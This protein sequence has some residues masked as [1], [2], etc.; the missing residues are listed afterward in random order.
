MIA[1]LLIIFASSG[2]GAGPTSGQIA[3][4]AGTEQE[5]RCVHV[6][7]VASGALA[8][9]GQGRRDGAPTW[10][11]DG[12][13]LA[14]VTD[15]P[16]KGTGVRLVHSDGSG[17]QILGHSAENV[18]GPARWSPDGSKLAYTSGEGLVQRVMV[19]DITSGQETAW[20]G[21]KVPLL[22][23][24][25]VN[26]SQ[27]VAVGV[28]GLPGEQ[29]TDLYW[30]TPKGANPAAELLASTGSYAE[31]APAADREGSAIAYESND[32]GDREIFVHIMKRGTVDVSNHRTPDWNPVVSPDGAWVAFESF[33]TG[34]RGIFRVNPVRVLVSEVAASAEWDD[35]APTWSPDGAWVAF[36]SNRTGAPRLHV[37]DLTGE[38]VKA[39][40]DHPLQDLA[41][42]WRPESK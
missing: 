21:D 4:L 29:T 41:P 37:T 2:W 8:K 32:G 34:R 18:M 31:W 17:E 14:Y 1:S 28:V 16:E 5:D 23:P 9:V 3:F 12:A 11:P 7:D 36:I 13:W 35:W 39:L 33:R 19:Y 6:L 25:W 10:S 22:H 27:I 26:N 38:N 20:G 30:V 15:G 40:T 24:V 42:A